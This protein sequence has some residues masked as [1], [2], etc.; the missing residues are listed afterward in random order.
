M[1]TLTKFVFAL[2]AAPAAAEASR[3]GVDV[4][5]PGGLWLLALGLAGLGLRFG[6]RR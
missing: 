5:A 4:A 1:S 2:L 6:R 3:G